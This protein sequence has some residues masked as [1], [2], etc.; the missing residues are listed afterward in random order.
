MGETDDA[1]AGG[2]P[3]P[4]AQVLADQL[5]LVP[6]DEIDLSYG[7]GGT[8]LDDTHVAAETIHFP[9]KWLRTFTKADPKHLFFSRGDGDSMV[10]TIFHEDIVLVDRS[11]A[12]INR[13]DSIWAIAFG[14]ILMLKRLRAMPDGSYKIMSDNPAVS[15]ETAVD[16]EMS[17]I[18]RV[19]ATIRRN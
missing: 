4:P 15:D 11:Q 3:T 5:Q 2:S 14:N 12:S 13:Q 17:V 18:G 16:D 10:P 6:I 7:M 19:V 1:V 9:L 8:Y